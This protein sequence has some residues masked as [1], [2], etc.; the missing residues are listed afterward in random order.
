MSECSFPPF[1]T[2]DTLVTGMTG[3]GARDF[4]YRMIIQSRS[5]NLTQPNHDLN[6]SKTEIDLRM[7]HE[8]KEGK[9]TW[10]AHKIEKLLQIPLKRFSSESLFQFSNLTN[11]ARSSI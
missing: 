8:R 6:Y 11:A 4:L 5:G 7:I 2:S 9:K 1:N 3:V 10:C